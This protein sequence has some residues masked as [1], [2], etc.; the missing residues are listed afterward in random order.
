V[1]DFDEAAKTP[2][3]F[4]LVR[5]GASALLYEDRDLLS[6]R[7]RSPGWSLPATARVCARQR[8]SFWTTGYFWLRELFYRIDASSASASG[9]SS[10]NRKGESRRRGLSL[11]TQSEPF[12][13]RR[14]N[15][16]TVR[17]AP[18]SA[19]LGRP[20]C[21]ALGSCAGQP[22]YAKQGR[23]SLM[24]EPGALP[25]FLGK[26]LAAGSKRPLIARRIRG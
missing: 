5:L 2:Y 24:L 21:A 7:R 15:D 23:H 4:D 16:D 25:I 6:R 22:W 11:A 12:L 20:R 3:P 9:R 13:S 17:V 10:L 18:E 26:G 19:V 14:L 1:N 8:R